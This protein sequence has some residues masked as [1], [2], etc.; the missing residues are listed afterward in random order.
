[1][2]RG[3]LNDDDERTSEEPADPNPAT[4]LPTT[5]IVDETAAPESTDPAMEIILERRKMRLMEKSL[6][7]FPKTNWKAQTQS[8]KADEYQPT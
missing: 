3:G 5:S 4:A 7:A 1:M 2:E 8:L 6:Y